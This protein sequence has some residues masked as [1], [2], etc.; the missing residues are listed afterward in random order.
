MCNKLFGLIRSLAM[1]TI[2]VAFSLS[3]IPAFAKSFTTFDAPGAG[4]S[5]GQGTFAF[6]INPGGAV[7][8]Y[9]IDASNVF[10]GFV[11]APRGTITTFDAP[12]A[13]TSPGQGTLAFGKNPAGAITGCY[14]DTSNV[15]HGFVRPHDGTFT[16]FDAPDAGTGA[17]QGT[18][19]FK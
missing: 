15:A 4:T 10:H 6:G 7:I 14:V 11:R 18:L 5:P 16:T 8:G 2:G 19:S 3:T 1:F 12:G 13:T 17:N 9:Y